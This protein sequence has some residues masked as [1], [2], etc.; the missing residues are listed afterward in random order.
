MVRSAVG[1]SDNTPSPHIPQRGQ[2]SDDGSEIT[3]GNKSRHVFKQNGSRLY[4]A[5][6]FTGCGPHVS[7]VI[8]GSLLAGDGEGLAGKARCNHV[9]NASVLLGCT[10]LNEL[11]HVS[12]D[13]SDGQ[14]S[15]CNSGS[16]NALAIFVPLDIANWPPS[17]KVRAQESTTGS[18]EQGEFVHATSPKLEPMYDDM[19]RSSSR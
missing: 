2:V 14:V 15:V 7:L 13:R 19:A 3:A 17:E 6:D 4:S 5:N 9:R 11:T 16:D 1:S 18:G 12:E 8:C 10:G